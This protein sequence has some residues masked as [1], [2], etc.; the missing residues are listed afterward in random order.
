MNEVNNMSLQMLL[1]HNDYNKLVKQN[2]SEF[3]NIK[4]SPCDIK[5]HKEEI[6]Q[7]IIKLID[8]DVDNLNNKLVTIFQDFTNELFKHWELLKVKQDNKFNKN[9]DSIKEDK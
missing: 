6:I 1:G 9:D 2:P 8:N 3:Q 5:V 4:H 7:T